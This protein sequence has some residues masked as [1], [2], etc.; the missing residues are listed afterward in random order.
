M[1]SVTPCICGQILFFMPLSQEQ[2]PPLS[3]SYTVIITLAF[4]YQL[5]NGLSP[6]FVV[7]SA[8]SALPAMK[9]S[10]R[11]VRAKRPVIAVYMGSMTSKLVGNRMSK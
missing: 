3:S 6:F 1:S 10:C 11:Y 2:A 8:M 4:L 5:S 9:S 7:V